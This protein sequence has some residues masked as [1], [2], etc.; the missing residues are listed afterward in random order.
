[1]IKGPSYGQGSKEKLKSQWR[2]QQ[3]KAALAAL[4]LP[5]AELKAMFDMLN[6]ELPKQ[7]CD[8]TR[9]LT[10]SWLAGRGHD[11]D[12]VFDWLETQGGF[13]DCEVLFNVP[14]QVDEAAKA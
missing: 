10:R 12:R 7:G 8:H 13:C 4:P 1:M 2:G 3:R 5:V 9:R 14:E 6:L 11:I